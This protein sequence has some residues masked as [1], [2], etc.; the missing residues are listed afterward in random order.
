MYLHYLLTSPK[1]EMLYRVFKAM[2]RETTK[3]D[4][5]EIVQNDLND[6]KIHESFDEIRKI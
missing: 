2:M 4:W 6:Y 1:E 5:I 3:G